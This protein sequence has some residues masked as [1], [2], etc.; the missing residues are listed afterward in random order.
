[1]IQQPTFLGL[2]LRTV[3]HRRGLVTG[4]YALLLLFVVPLLMRGNG[5][6]IPGGMIIQTFTLGALFG[7]LRGG[8]VVKSYTEAPDPTEASS[9]TTL[10]LSD[11]SV[12]RP[13]Y[14]LDERERSA[15]DHAHYVA[16][17][18]LLILLGVA[19]AVL[20]LT[21]GWTLTFFERNA[22]TLLW[23]MLL[24]ALSLPQCVILWTEPEP[25]PEGSLTLVDAKR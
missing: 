5:H 14:L 17:R 8:G 7:G 12:L 19:M 10:H 1:M 20:G 9:L 16:Y 23:A 2:S 15:R 21:Q 25:L 22:G 6:L 24:I 4:Y 18:I 13:S 11:Y 3:G